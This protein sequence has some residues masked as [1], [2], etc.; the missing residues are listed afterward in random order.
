MLQFTV[1]HP[2]SS[3]NQG[4][5]L[6]LL[7]TFLTLEWLLV[8]HDLGFTMLYTCFL[9]QGFVLL[10]TLGEMCIESLEFVKEILSF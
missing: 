5:G 3:Q 4:F 2:L 9:Q 8:K 1:L 10:A 6:L 7:T